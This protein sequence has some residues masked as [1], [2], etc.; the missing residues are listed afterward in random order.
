MTLKQVNILI[1]DRQDDVSSLAEAGITM[2]WLYANRSEPDVTKNVFLVSQPAASDKG[3]VVSA[4][5]CH[6][7]RTR[8]Q[9]LAMNRRPRVSPELRT[10]SLQAICCLTTT[11][12]LVVSEVECDVTLALCTCSAR[13]RESFIVCCEEIQVNE[14]QHIRRHYNLLCD[15]RDNGPHLNPGY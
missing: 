9:P 8:C 15:E 10:T 2:C 1:Y 12:S 7:P 11:R 3:D 14:G 4:S 6:G 5:P 13:S